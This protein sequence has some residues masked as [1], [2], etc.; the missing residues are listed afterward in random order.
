IFQGLQRVIAARK[1]LP[2]LHAQAGAHA[3]WTHNEHVFGLLRDSPRGRVL[4][5]GNFSEAPQIVPAYRLAEMGFGGRLIDR[6][7][8]R[9][10][11]GHNDLA[12]EPYAYYWVQV[13]EG[14]G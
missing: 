5:L 9:E 6:L 14:V 11:A 10:L 12:L 3:V 1:K 8:G 2:A 4:I 13:D 7:S